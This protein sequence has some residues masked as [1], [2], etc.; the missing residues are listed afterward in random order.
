MKTKWNKLKNQI[1]QN[2]NKSSQFNNLIACG[3]IWKLFRCEEKEN[4]LG[5]SASSRWESKL[6]RRCLRTSSMDGLVFWPPEWIV[7]SSGIRQT[8]LHGIDIEDPLSVYRALKMRNH[9]QRCHGKCPAL[10]SIILF[11]KSN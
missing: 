9:F 7:I 2:G 4:R 10:F 11:P 1:K 6:C 5:W 8:L 3:F